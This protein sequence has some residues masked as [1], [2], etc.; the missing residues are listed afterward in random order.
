MGTRLANSGRVRCNRF[1][2][3]AH[4][5]LLVGTLVVIVGTAFSP[6]QMP[7]YRTCGTVVIFFAIVCMLVLALFEK[8]SSKDIR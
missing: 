5:L 2:Y 1:I 8:L 4:G 6:N 3:R 7:K